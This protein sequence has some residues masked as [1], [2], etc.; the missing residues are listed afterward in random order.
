MSRGP[1]PGPVTVLRGHQSDVQA[2]VFHPQ[3]DL[4]YSG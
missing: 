3:L 1:A 4:L 2:L